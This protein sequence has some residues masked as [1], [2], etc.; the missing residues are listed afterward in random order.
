MNYISREK[1]GRLARKPTSQPAGGE[2]QA[3]NAIS[4]EIAW[5]IN[6][7]IFHRCRTRWIVVCVLSPPS[8]L[9]FPLLLTASHLPPLPA[10]PVFIPFIRSA[11]FLGYF[12]NDTLCN[13]N[14]CRRNELEEVFQDATSRHSPLALRSL[15]LSLSHPLVLAISRLLATIHPASLSFSFP[16]VSSAKCQRALLSSFSGR[17]PRESPHHRILPRS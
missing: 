15:S 4:R 14:Y 5:A 11:R 10:Y 3:G 17:I 2:G 13:V 16:L 9:L 1:R 7:N 12:H 8:T 6:R